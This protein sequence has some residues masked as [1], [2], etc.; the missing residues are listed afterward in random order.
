M[1]K[2]T[3]ASRGSRLAL[4]QAEQ[5]KGRLLARHP[6]LQAE[7]LVLKTQGDITLDVPLA[8]IGGKGLFVKE[9]EEALLDGR[10]DFAVHSMKDVPMNLPDGL[11]LGTVLEREDARDMFLSVRYENL[12]ALPSGAKVGT[13]SLRRQAQLLALRPDLDIASL[14]GNIDTRLEKLMNGEFDAI[15]MAAAGL[16][17][18]GL[19]APYMTALSDDTF[20]P[21]A[22]QGALGLE[23]HAERTDVAAL[24]AFMDHA[25]THRAVTAERGFLAGLDGGCQT[26][27]AAH[28]AVKNGELVLTGLLAD[29]AGQRVFR[30]RASAGATCPPEEAR[31]LGLALAAKI[32]TSGGNALLEELFASIP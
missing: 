32:R 16:S 6:G 7:I 26:P 21:A 3:I 12:D 1:K 8:K 18:I 13:S 27:I 23:Y 28:A 10:A 22:G 5:I 2:L 29:T 17:R 20:L 25:E 15:V 4:W 31:E 30:E 19:T 24:L 11:V 9:I 14:R